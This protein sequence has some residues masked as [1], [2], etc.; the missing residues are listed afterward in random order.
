M[1][2]ITPIWDTQSRELRLGAHVVKQFK[3][4]AITQEAVLQAFSEEGWPTRIDDPLPPSPNICP[5]RRLHDTIK[6]L[7]RRRVNKF[8]KFRGDGTGEGVLLE[9]VANEINDKLNQ[10]EDLLRT[11]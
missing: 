5:K 2:D 9:I 6:C 8:I 4:P 10:I 7:N 1:T 11:S 3:W